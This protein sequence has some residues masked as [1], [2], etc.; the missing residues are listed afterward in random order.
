[1]RTPKFIIGQSVLGADTYICHLRKPGIV[2]RVYLPKTQRE[3]ADYFLV[4][5]KEKKNK[6]YSVCGVFCEWEKPTRSE[7]RRVEQ[8][9]ARMIDW[10]IGINK[11][12]KIK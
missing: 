5:K 9:M 2:C 1:M 8:I 11:I 6:I 12:H 7:Q 3:E 4:V 10:Y